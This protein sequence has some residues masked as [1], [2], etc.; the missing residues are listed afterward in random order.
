[1]A[2]NLKPQNPSNVFQHQS[3]PSNRQR[4][5]GGVRQEERATMSARSAST[6]P[7]R[8]GRGQRALPLDRKLSRSKN[9]NRGIEKRE[10]L[11]LWI[12]PIAKLRTKQKAQ[13]EK[14]SVSQTG[15]AIYERAIQ[16]DIDMQYGALL[17][18]VLERGM[19]KNLREEEKQTLLLARL[20]YEV[21]QIRGIVT[22]ILGR[23][24]GVTQEIRTTIL[25][26]SGN[27]ALTNITRWTPQ[28]REIMRRLETWLHEEWKRRKQ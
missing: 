12:S 25:K 13:N 8:S 4:P 2:N 9:T 18:P 10:P 17:E 24:P 14:L 6:Q 19:M 21:G 7:L 22:N 16:A 26:E 28:I 27:S 15:A 20:T 11:T 5:R 3:H 1:M 23:T